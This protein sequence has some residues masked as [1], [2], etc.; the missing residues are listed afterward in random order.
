[1]THWNDCIIRNSGKPEIPNSPCPYYI[2]PIEMKCSLFLKSIINNVS[3]VYVL[4][5]MNSDR[6]SKRARLQRLE[7]ADTQAS[8]SPAPSP[9]DVG[10]LDLLESSESQDK[11]PSSSFTCPLT[12]MAMFD[13]VLDAEGNTYERTAILEWLQRKK[14]S[15]LSRQPLHQRM[16]IPNIALRETIHEF[17][18][19]AWVAQK[20][21]E[22]IQIAVSDPPLHSL[23]FRTKIDGFLEYASTEIGG[24]NLCLDAEGY[25]AFRYDEV[26]VILYVP[27]KVGIFCF[28]TRE[29][30]P[31]VTESMK[32][33]LLELNYLQGKSR[34]SKVRSTQQLLR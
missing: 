4:Q 11:M 18:G 34:Q 19:P 29:L 23:S 7:K 31:R 24:I 6:K 25:C 15:P 2:A 32:D 13:P 10:S 14:N 3:L 17:M 8:T 20:E 22:R 16:L 21:G 1:M 26:R 5:M 28:Y 27:E 33:R 30:V 9:Q 12:M